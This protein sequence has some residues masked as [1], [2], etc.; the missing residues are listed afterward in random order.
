MGFLT[1]E[2]LILRKDIQQLPLVQKYYNELK[3]KY[4]PDFEYLQEF[5]QKVMVKKGY[6]M[7]NPQQNE[8]VEKLFAISSHY[9]AITPL[10]K[11]PKKDKDLK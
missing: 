8:D 2:V 1:T 10:G 5:A 7:D 4:N 6:V 9:M 11:T 3:Q